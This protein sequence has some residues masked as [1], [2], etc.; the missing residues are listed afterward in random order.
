MVTDTKYLRQR[1]GRWLVQLAVPKKL[2][3]HFGKA[4]LEK[5]LGTADLQVAQKRKHAVIA[6]FHAAI[7]RA[8]QAKPITQAEMAAAAREELR[9][10]Y[11]AAEREYRS[12]GWV[13]V[14]PAELLVEEHVRG[15][16]DDTFLLFADSEI[17][18]QAKAVI[19]KLGAEE[20]PDTVETMCR[21]LFQAKLDAY[22]LVAS[23]R[24]PPPLP[25]RG[26]LPRHR[27]E[28]SAPPI[29]EAA[30]LFLTERQRDP[31]ARLTA[32]TEVQFRATFRLFA[33]YTDDAP[34]DSV[35]RQ[36]AA[37]F[38]DALAG[39]DRHYGRGDGAAS[40][41]LAELLKRFPAEDGTGLSNRTLN[42]HAGPLR[43]LFKW[44]KRRTLVDG[45]NPFSDL[46]RPKAK[47]S[48]TT[49]LP[50]DV[51]EL[52]RLF[53]GARFDVKL[54]RHDLPSSLPLIMAI[55]LYSGLRQGEICE[56]DVEDVKR[57]GEV[58]FFDITEAK[59][60]AGVR[61]VPVHSMLI[62]VG[63]LGYVEAVGSGPLFSG[64]A[65][66]G[67]NNKRGRTVAKRF[68]AYRRQRGV[69]R[70][71]VTFHSFRKCFVRALELAK[72][73][74]DR[75]ALVVGHERGFTYRVYNPEGLD[76]AALQEVVE[77]VRY[78]G[79][80]LPGL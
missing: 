32:Q 36:T 31:N 12:G 46:S 40:L 18:K 41:S 34:I 57:E 9:R 59:S 54:R 24:E 76:M 65:P 71:R 4:V 70:E 1:R 52:N 25:G 77:A 11:T 17:E 72:V 38:L 51:D 66:G 47:I 14:T 67:P 15:D 79:F 45:D 37:G 20:T 42:R 75:A 62:A 74:S 2:Q 26:P 63:L 69:D 21:A 10:A 22:G 8:R 49:W 19:E 7:G 33:D 80:R 35:T 60:E 55:A 27:P 6:D 13:D 23:H 3:N 28:G 53:D 44:A 68:P 78:E 73:D 64:V 16:R 5:Y 58:S 30:D 43:M 39:L 48:D 61:R 50:F 56:L 29:S